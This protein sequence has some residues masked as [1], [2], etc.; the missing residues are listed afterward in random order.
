MKRLWIAMA[1]LASVPAPAPADAQ[2]APA[3][4]PMTLGQFLTHWDEAQKAGVMAK[5]SPDTRAAMRAIQ[6]GAMR[7]RVMVETDKE[8][9]RPPRSCPPPIGTAKLSSQDI[10]PKLKALPKADHAKPFEDVLI[11]ILYDLYPCPP[12]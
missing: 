7:Y 11:P 5:M 12:G 6:R 8:M 1:M 3:E 2:T 9:G 4:T 10:I